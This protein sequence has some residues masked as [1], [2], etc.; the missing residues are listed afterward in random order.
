M[1][2]STQILIVISIVLM[3]SVIDSISNYL[4]SLKV[5]Q[6]IEFLNKSQDII[7]NSAKLHRSILEMQSSFRGYLLTSDPNFLENYSNG[8]KNVPVL[9]SELNVLITANEKQLAIL[10]SI[11]NLHQQWI[12]YASIMIVA[13]SK[14]TSSEKDRQ[15]YAQLF[16][17]KLK[18]QVGK[19]LNDNITKLFVEFDRSEYKLRSLH[20]NNLIISINR[21]HTFSIIFFSLTVIIGVG[22]TIFIL[23]IFS[24]RINTM[25]HLA[26]SI[27]KGNFD[28]ITDTNNDEM[29]RLSSSLNLMS[30]NLNKNIQEL[31]KRNEELDKFAYVVSHDLKAPIRGIHNVLK[32]I[33]EDLGPELSQQMKKYLKIIP[34]R[35]KRME[36]LI[37]GLLNY[38]RLR[39]KTEPEHIDVNILVNEIVEENV[40]ENINV[41][42]NN[43]PVFTTE[44]LKL[45]QVFTNLIGNSVKY[46]EQEQGT[47]DISCVKFHH[48]YQ[49]S[50][51]D[52]GI[53][54]DPEYHAKVFE[55]FQ[56][57]REKGE[58]ES[59]G[60]GLA[61]VKKIIDEQQGT[62]KINSTLG[63]GAEFI[64]TWP[65]TN[66]K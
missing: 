22:S 10:D 33:E 1:K 53:G 65:G 41:V 26:E 7:R 51:K 13:N 23:R 50:V 45:E 63:K 61:I 38:A 52:N 40:P 17:G 35:T 24:R 8:L 37:N 5:E 48:H 60:I 11:N 43:L 14:S 55:M 54:I 56:T 34:Q 9:Y 12:N 15:T 28:K 27:S 31:I 29:T 16:D 42:T 58:M 47:I 4:L 57:L 20:S 6:N 39:E 49:F 2:L 62:I 66:S 64:F 36:D 59:T 30:A 44:R 19:K 18:K 21:T 46:I 25:V 3:L 32:W